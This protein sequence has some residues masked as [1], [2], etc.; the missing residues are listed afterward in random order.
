MNDSLLTQT[1]REELVSACRTTVGDELRSITFFTD[2]GLEQVYLRSD[3][4][5]TADLV[6][7]AEQERLGFRSQQAYRQTQLGEYIATVRMFEDGYLVRVLDESSGVWVTADS[8]SIER[9][10]EL[11]SVLKPVL[12][13]LEFEPSPD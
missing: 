9:F 1:A 8:M 13:D 10:E 7:F 5:Q 4:S 3:L 11:A 2:D 12:A 6:G